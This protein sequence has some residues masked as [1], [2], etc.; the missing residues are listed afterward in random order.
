MLAGDAGV[1]E[2]AKRAGATV[3]VPF[4]PGRTD[5]TQALT[6]VESFAVLEPAADGFR[7]FAKA[8]LTRPTPELLV[9]R[10]QQLSLSV[11]EMTVLVGGLRVL[12]ANFGDSAQGVFTKRPETLTNDFFVH[13]RDNGTGWKPTSIGYEGL[14]RK[15]GQVRWTAS[16]VDLIFGSNSQLRAVAEVYA[17]ADGKEKFVQDFA[18]AWSKVMHLDRFDLAGAQRP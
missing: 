17:S 3:R 18:A 8:G 6:D 10:A 13:L 11:P 9:D 15:S 2:A 1:E 7:N 12:G 5:A 14:D 16:A 4:A